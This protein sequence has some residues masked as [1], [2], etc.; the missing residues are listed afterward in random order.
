MP[1]TN[2]Q[3]VID[4]LGGNYDTINCPKMDPYIKAANLLVTRVNDCAEERGV[5]LTSTELTE[6][7]RW[8]AAHFYTINDPIYKSK[9][10]G[11][12]SATY[13]DRS[14]LDVAK[15]LDYSGCLNAIMN[16]QRAYFDWLGK[17][18]SDQIDI[19]DRD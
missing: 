9:T 14:Y 15:N 10:T 5:T 12:S 13:F 8:M 1:R 2:A 18:P 3:A 7:E 6:I 11:D 16:N 4:I 17:I 19:D